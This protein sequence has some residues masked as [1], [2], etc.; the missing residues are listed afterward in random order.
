MSDGW[1]PI[2]KVPDGEYLRL[3]VIEDG[4]VHALVFVCRLVDSAWIDRAGRHVEVR[5]THWQ[6]W[7][8]S[9]DGE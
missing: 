1:R 9:G 7:D 2:S 6:P 5:P 4:H 8:S 3:S